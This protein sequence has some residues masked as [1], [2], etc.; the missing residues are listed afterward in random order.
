MCSLPSGLILIGWAGG[1]IG[2]ILPWVSSL[3]FTWVIVA[4]ELK[5]ASEHAYNYVF[6]AR[7]SLS[8]PLIKRV[9][10]GNSR[11]FRCVLDHCFFLRKV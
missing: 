11:I 3:L 10:R 7:P 6:H 2:I 1:G 4:R 9:D 8:Q 5:K